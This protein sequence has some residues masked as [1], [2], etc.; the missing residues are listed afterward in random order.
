MGKDITLAVS[1]SFM[2]SHDSASE[3]NP[4][5]E[6]EQKVK[7]KARELVERSKNPQ[8]GLEQYPSDAR[9]ME[10][11]LDEDRSDEVT[12][13]FCDLARYEEGGIVAFCEWLTENCPSMLYG[14]HTMWIMME[15]DGITEEKIR[16][17]YLKVGYDIYDQK[18]ETVIDSKSVNRGEDDSKD[19]VMLKIMI[20][21]ALA[22]IGINVILYF[23]YI[24]FRAS[25]YETGDEISDDMGGDYAIFASSKTHDCEE[26][27]VSVQKKGSMI[28]NSK[29]NETVQMWKGN[30]VTAICD[31]FYNGDG[32][33]FVGTTTL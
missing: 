3:S 11:Y 5:F 7:E 1:P 24:D 27:W 19:S 8:E 12:M 25:I 9:S 30:R 29:S 28:I 21:S 22:I 33:I 14:N 20:I 32:W 10:K 2:A 23:Q 31:S 13:Y 15:E 16:E 6:F 4:L 26:D 18:K 17:I